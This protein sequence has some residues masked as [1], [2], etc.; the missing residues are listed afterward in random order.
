MSVVIAVASESAVPAA[1][2]VTA[3]ENVI[4]GVLIVGLVPK[5]KAPVP[6]SSVITADKVELVP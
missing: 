5:T 2:T 6:V 1:L 3:L 4:A